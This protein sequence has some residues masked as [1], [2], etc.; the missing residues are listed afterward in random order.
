[1]DARSYIS[2]GVS[3]ESVPFDDAKRAIRAASLGLYELRVLRLRVPMEMIS[4]TFEDPQNDD[5]VA[6]ATGFRVLT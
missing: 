4:L 5:A 3:I 6:L 2:G 1:M